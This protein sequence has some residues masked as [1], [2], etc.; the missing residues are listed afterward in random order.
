MLRAKLSIIFVVGLGLIPRIIHAEEYKSIRGGF[1][2]DFPA[3]V[4]VLNYDK[5][6]WVCTSTEF[7]NDIFIMHQVA[8]MLERPG[9]PL[10]FNTDEEYREFLTI[11]IQGVMQSTYTDAKLVHSDYFLWENE[12]QSIRYSFSGVMKDYNI[13]VQNEGIVVIHD[14][15][16][17]K[18]SAIYPVRFKDDKQVRNSLKYLFKSFHVF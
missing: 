4:E 12:Y 8:I 7:N 10:S 15:K 2:V 6:S 13:P 18:V 11:F 17:K 9:G 16:I 14:N 5:Y 3:E 1:R